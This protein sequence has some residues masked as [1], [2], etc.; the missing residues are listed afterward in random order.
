MFCVASCNRSPNSAT[1]NIAPDTSVE[2]EHLYG[3]YR[4]SATP[5]EVAEAGGLDAL[6][7]LYLSKEGKFSLN[8]DGEKTSGTYTY[9]PGSLTLKD[10]ETGSETHF[11]V[12]KDGVEICYADD[13]SLGF[14]RVAAAE[15]K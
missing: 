12:L 13:P 1:E 6:P 11:N 14:I 3:K 2:A 5:E 7:T 8:V 15:K 4:M 10:S 9:S